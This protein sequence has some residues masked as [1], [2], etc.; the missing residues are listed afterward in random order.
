MQLLSGPA[1]VSLSKI[2]R[3]RKEGESI[4]LDSNEKA[5]SPFCDLV[6]LERKA[7][8][9]GFLLIYIHLCVCVCLRLFACFRVCQMLG[10]PR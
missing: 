5:T 8:K 3:L 9:C 7:S 2:S 6:S 10:F 4:D 1:S